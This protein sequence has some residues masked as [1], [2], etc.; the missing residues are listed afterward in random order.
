MTRY[1][2]DSGIPG[3]IGIIPNPGDTIIFTGTQIHIE[4]AKYRGEQ[5]ERFARECD[6]HFWFDDEKPELEI[7]TVPK[8]EVV[9]RDS[10]G[11]LFVCN[12][13]SF[14]REEEPMYYLDQKRRCFRIAQNSRKFLDCGMKWRDSLIPSDAI[15][16]FASKEKAKKKFNIIDLK[17]PLEDML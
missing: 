15:E 2:D 11:G 12:G 3:C 10:C 7:Y 9:G 1:Y 8:M 16:V 5:S 17:E 4:S 6:F 13:G 14:L